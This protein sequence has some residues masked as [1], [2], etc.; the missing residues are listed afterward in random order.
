MNKKVFG[1][2]LIIVMSF[3][4]FA[5]SKTGDNSDDE[6]Y[7]GEE[8]IGNVEE[9]R[10]NKDK[11]MLSELAYNIRITLVEGYGDV[12]ASLTRVRVDG[13]GRIRI[14]ALFDTTTE[15]GQGFVNAL[16]NNLGTEYIELS[17]K[18]KE[19][20]TVFIEDFDGVKGEFTIQVESEKCEMKFYIDQR[21]KI[22]E[23]S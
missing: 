16:H 13:E 11:N 12:N 8:L 3:T 9:A 18:M 15:E 2:I 21:G 6:A 19:D 10:L 14:A 7:L 5:C 4:M 22:H 17:S 23:R 20:C 1:F